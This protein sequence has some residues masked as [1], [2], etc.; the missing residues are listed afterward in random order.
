[1]TD[2]RVHISPF[3]VFYCCWF[4]VCAQRGLICVAMGKSRKRE[5]TVRDDKTEER[6]K[7]RRK[8]KKDIAVTHALLV[9]NPLT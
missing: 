5:K 4:A 9:H 1:V 3:V 8:S 6:M 7:K 2:F